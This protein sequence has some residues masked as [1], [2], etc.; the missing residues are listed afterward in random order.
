MKFSRLSYL[1]VLVF[2]SLSIAEQGFAQ[3]GCHRETYDGHEYD[4]CS[5]TT[6]VGIPGTM[7]LT[8]LELS[9]FWGGWGWGQNG[10]SGSSNDWNQQGNVGRGRE[11]EPPLPPHDRE[12]ECVYV[13]SGAKQRNSKSLKNTIETIADRLSSNRECAELINGNPKTLNAVSPDHLRLGIAESVLANLIRSD[14]IRFLYSSKY[15]DESMRSA[16]YLPDWSKNG[17]DNSNLGVDENGK[18][19]KPDQIL[20]NPYVWSMISDE[21]RLYL[22]L[23]EL[24]HAADAA[25]TG[26]AGGLSRHCPVEPEILPDGSVVVGDLGHA[27]CDELYN[28]YKNAIINLCGTGS[29][30]G[31]PYYDECPKTN[32]NTLESTGTR[33]DN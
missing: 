33:A 4:V 6:V 13:S 15:W 18:P 16:A 10:D 31:V 23:H 28:E 12:R 8:P 7:E 27:D 25:V 20:L 30:T 11:D 3:D 21:Q 24:G 9:W 14:S 19:L 26:G 5:T 29:M 17:G 1:S 2:A 22:L 32:S